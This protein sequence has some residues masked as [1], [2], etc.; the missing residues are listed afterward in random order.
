ME[1]VA[2]L[3]VTGKY[4]GQQYTGMITNIFST[5]SADFVTLTVELDQPINVFAVGQINKFEANY[6]EGNL[7]GIR[8][9]SINLI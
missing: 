9:M 6:R 5:P 8:K 3:K 7:D 2:N 4:M 1:T